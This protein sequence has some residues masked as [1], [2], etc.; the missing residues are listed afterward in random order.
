MTTTNSYWTGR[1]ILVFDIRSLSS[2]D[3]DDIINVWELAGLP[4]KK[5]GRDSKKEIER[6]LSCDSIIFRGCYVKGQLGGVVIGTLDGRKGYINRLAVIPGFQRKGLAKALIEELERIFRE[7]GIKVIEVLI[8][9]HSPESKKLFNGL[10][11]K[12]HDDITYYSKRE[13]KHV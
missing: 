11:Y 7:R 9:D 3:Y 12:P 4:Y 10:G 2:Q 5:K 13:S 6:Q 1:D 8:D